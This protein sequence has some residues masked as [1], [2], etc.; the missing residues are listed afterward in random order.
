MT[1]VSVAASESRTA[2]PPPPVP[3]VPPGRRAR[4][5]PRRK[6]LLAVGAMV[7]A[8]VALTA[9]FM[10]DVLP[11]TGSGTGGSP[12]EALSY[13]AARALSESA[14]AKVPDGP[15]TASSATAYDVDMTTPIV[16]ALGLYSA[17]ALP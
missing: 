17:Q 15:W 7:V 2:D 1:A 4:G 12:G 14:V 3:E 6:V 16:Q 11:R 10:F 8:V 9:V 13:F 5:R